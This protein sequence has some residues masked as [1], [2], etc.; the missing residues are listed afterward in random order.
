MTPFLGI[1]YEFFAFAIVQLPIFNFV[2][3]FFSW[4]IISFHSCVPLIELF[5]PK[6]LWILSFF[7]LI[8]VYLITIDVWFVLPSFSWQILLHFWSYSF[9]TWHDRSV[10]HRLLSWPFNHHLILVERIIDFSWRVL[11][12]WSWEVRFLFWPWR[13]I[14]KWWKQYIA[15]LIDLIS[16]VPDT[17]FDCV[18]DVLE[19]WLHLDLHSCLEVPH[20]DPY[21]VCTCL[22][23]C[24][25]DTFLTEVF[26]L[27]NVGDH[28]G[29]EFCLRWAE[30]FFEAIGMEVEG[31]GLMVRFRNEEDGLWLLEGL[32]FLGD[33][34]VGD[35]F[36]LLRGG[37][38]L[39][40]LVF[41]LELQ[42][43]AREYN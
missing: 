24:L 3:L 23:Y 33:P 4:K 18:V 17:C 38:L 12:W 16:A 40:A 20:V 10:R 13:S 22:D 31:V 14:S 11:Q 43:H 26:S 34:W 30:D 9:L 25:V 29:W 32:R 7:F 5:F 1:S 21:E 8:F 37:G 27:F 42:E 19:H 36:L 41:V 35:L 39:L 6:W 28:E 15:A 2:F